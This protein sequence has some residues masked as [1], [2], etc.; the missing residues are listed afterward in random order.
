MTT[1]INKNVY[2]VGDLC[3][4]MTNEWDEICE[5][6]VFDNFQSVFTLEDGRK[7][8]QLSTAFGDGT[9]NDLDGNPYSV[10]SGTIGAVHVNNITDTEALNEALGNGLGHLHTFDTELTEDNCEYDNMV[11]YI[12]GVTIDTDYG[13]ESDNE[14]FDVMDEDEILE[15]VALF[16]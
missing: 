11:L 3:Y 14:E 1:E 9:Y 5:L 4:V 8:I 12:G 15:R 2:Y 13:P 16:G 10:D 6:A 7:Y